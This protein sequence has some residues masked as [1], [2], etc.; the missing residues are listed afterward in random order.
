MYAFQGRAGAGY[1][2]DRTP[3]YADGRRTSI[4]ANLSAFYRLQ[5]QFAVG[6]GLDSTSQRG[7]TSPDDQA[8]EY[9]SYGAA[10][11]GRFDSG[12]VALTTY[13]AFYL[14]ERAEDDHGI[15]RTLD[16]RGPG[17]GLAMTYRFPIGSTWSLDVG[18]YVNGFAQ[19]LEGDEVARGETVRSVSA[20]LLLGVTVGGPSPE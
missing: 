3:G 14:G 13:V 6:L 7:G 10:L 4:G 20:G 17:A 12:P 15:A 8:L 2:G 16:L 9:N 1:V 19:R 5:E 18:P 11:Q